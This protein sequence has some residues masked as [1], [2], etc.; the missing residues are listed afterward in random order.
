MV[1]HLPD[2]V[3]DKENHGG[4]EA[5]VQLGHLTLAHVSNLVLEG[6]HLTKTCSKEKLTISL[7]VI[8]LP[9]TPKSRQKRRGWLEKTLVVEAMVRPGTMS[10][11]RGSRGE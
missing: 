7:F 11:R 4:D 10:R 8:L 2:E 9:M 3:V 5:G 6:D 1:H